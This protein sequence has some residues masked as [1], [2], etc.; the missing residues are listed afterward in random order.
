MTRRDLARVAA[1]ERAAFDRD[2]WPLQA[3]KDLLA[4]FAQA[5]PARGALWVAEDPGTGD[6]LGYAGVEVSALL[7]E[8]DIVNIAVA[9]EHRRRGVGRLFIDRIVRLCRRRGVPLLWLRVRASNRGARRFYRQMGFRERGRF[10]GYYLDPDEP[11]VIMALE[12]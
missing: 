7:G 6:I 11:A 4:A 8:M 1:I 3:F 9:A 12:M 2:A 5:K 10:Q